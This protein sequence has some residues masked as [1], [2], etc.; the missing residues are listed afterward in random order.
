MKLPEKEKKSSQLISEKL[1]AVEHPCASIGLIMSSS[2]IQ[3][4]SAGQTMASSSSR[5]VFDSEAPY[6]VGK[7][8]IFSGNPLHLLQ[9]S[10][11]L[12]ISHGRWGS[13]RYRGILLQCRPYSSSGRDQSEVASDGHGIL[14]SASSLPSM[15]SQLIL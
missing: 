3:P 8:I 14:R 6:F 15:I 7:G 9:S 1:V 11:G 12:T 10:F 13:R 5:T 2:S 4:M